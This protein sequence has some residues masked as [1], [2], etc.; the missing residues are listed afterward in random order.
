M[1]RDYVRLNCEIASAVSKTD[2]AD[3]HRSWDE[4]RDHTNMISHRLTDLSAQLRESD[5]SRVSH[6]YFQSVPRA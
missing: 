1:H 6:P 4:I 5:E 2:R 3:V